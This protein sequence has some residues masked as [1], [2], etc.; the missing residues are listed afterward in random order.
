MS[1]VW[2]SRWVFILAAIGAAAGLGNLWRFPYMVY[3]NGGAAFLLAYLLI[4]FAFGI[5]LVIL[6]V[7]FGQRQKTDFVSSLGAVAGYFGRVIGWITLLIVVAL[8]GYYAAII[9]WGFNFLM[10]SPSLGWGSDAEGFFFGQ[11]LQLA[12]SPASYWPVS[13]PVLLGVLA[14][15]VAVYFSIFKGLKSVG[16]VVKWTVTLPFILLVLLLVNTL[17]LPG[18]MSGLGYF[19]VPTWSEL[20]QVELWKNALSQAF[21]SMNIGLCLTVVYASFNHARTGIVSSG[22]LIAIGDALVSLVAGLAMFGTLGWMAQSQGVALTEVITSGP[23]LAFVTFP[24]AL[25]QLPFWPEFFAVVFFLAILTLAI[26]SMF[27]LLEAVG[28]TLRGFWRWFGDLKTEI[29]TLYLCAFFA[30]WSLAFCGANGLYRL[31]VLDHFL[32]SHLFYLA[33]LGQVIVIGWFLPVA[34][35]RRMVNAQGGFQ[36]GAWFDVLV[37]WVAPLVYIGL[38]LAALPGELAGTYEGYDLSFIWAWGIVPMLLI[39][40]LSLWLGL[41]SADYER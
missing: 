33:L 31:D 16:S 40:V 3:E 20:L 22:F 10:A 1:S 12:E 18:A 27:A 28:Y 9:G 23:T 5:P 32:F 41:K 34:E 4:L 11:I 21:F 19:L 25:S 8:A 37:R 15:Y 13:V 29:S 36:L 2:S 7:A 14:T 39:V 6:E 24:T 38:Y 30:L 26:D 35:L 17:F